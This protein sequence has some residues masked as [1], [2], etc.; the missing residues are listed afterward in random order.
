MT[1]G[2]QQQDH[3]FGIAIPKSAPTQNNGQ[4]TA[5]K[6]QLARPARQKPR[7]GH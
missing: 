6:A 3:G 1:Q 5:T 4:K 7:S 2:F